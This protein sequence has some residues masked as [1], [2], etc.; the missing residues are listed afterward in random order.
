[1]LHLFRSRSGWV[2]RWAARTLPQYWCVPPHVVVIIPRP[3][4][5][6]CLSLL[7]VYGWICFICF[8][9]ASYLGY[10]CWDLLSNWLPSHEY[11]IS[12]Y[13]IFL[14]WI[15]ENLGWKNQLAF[16]HLFV[17]ANCTYLLYFLNF[18]SEVSYSNA[19]KSVYTYRTYLY[20]ISRLSSRNKY[21]VLFNTN[22]KTN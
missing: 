13:W 2:S 18:S 6:A 17:Q 11:W 15:I 4:L 5:A 1:M 21:K 12:Q 10:F 20:F 16:Y 7:F 8:S 9:L 3:F 14:L 19:R 22:W